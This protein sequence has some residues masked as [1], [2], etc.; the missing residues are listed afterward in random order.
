MT[1]ERQKAEIG[2]YLKERHFGENRIITNNGL[3][4]LFNISGTYLRKVINQLRI[5][6]VPICSNNEGYW[7]AGSPQEI[8]MTI[9]QLNSRIT[10]IKNAVKGLYSSMGCEPYCEE[11]V[12]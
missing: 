4:E 8:A 9:V 1:F 12:L 7:Y 10:G 3:C 2:E 5:D 11:E 6:G